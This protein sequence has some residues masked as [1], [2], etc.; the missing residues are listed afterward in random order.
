MP[1]PRQGTSSDG[2]SGIHTSPIYHLTSPIASFLKTSSIAKTAAEGATIV[3]DRRVPAERGLSGGRDFLLFRRAAC[4]PP[5]ACARRNAVDVPP[6]NP[7]A[8]K[9]VACCRVVRAVRSTTSKRPASRG[10]PLRSSTPPN[11]PVMDLSVRGRK[12]GFEPVTPGS[13]VQCSTI[14]LLHPQ[15]YFRC[16][17]PERAQQIL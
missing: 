8:A 6:R 9:P 2:V 5:E 15:R 11:R 12:T 3:I 10:R 1:L 17:V 14:E 7:P 13:T 16:C 4:S